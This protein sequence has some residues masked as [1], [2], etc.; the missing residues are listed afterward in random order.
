MNEILKPQNQALFALN[1]GALALANIGVKTFETTTGAAVSAVR[2]T[3]GLAL[4]AAGEERYD[5]VVSDTEPGSQYDGSWTSSNEEN[6]I[7]GDPARGFS[8]GKNLVRVV[9]TPQPQPTPR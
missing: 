5:F 4:R 6:G 1:A 8:A 3:I 7:M 9:T 2:G